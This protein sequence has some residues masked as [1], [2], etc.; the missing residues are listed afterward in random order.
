MNNITIHPPFRDLIPPLTEEEKRELEAAIVTD[1]CR[2][3]LTVWKEHGILLDGHH[4]FEICGRHD[5]PYQVFEVSFPTEADAKSWMIRNQLARRN[6]P[7]AVR[8]ELALKLK[9][10]LTEQEPASKGGR[11]RKGAST[12]LGQN[13]APVSGKRKTRDKLAEA[14]GVSH[15]T[16]TKGAKVLSS[17]NTE[18]IADY[19]AGKVSTNKAAR[20]VAE[21]KPST[22]RKSPKHM[23]LEETKAKIEAAL[24]GWDKAPQELR[25]EL[26]KFFIHYA[27]ELKD[28][29]E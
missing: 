20:L 26:S 19:K 27:W 22:A 12:K 17:G 6:L 2:D 3:P 13:S 24:K 14:A 1:G 4:R 7:E 25:I 5:L 21:D 16:F 23:G 15:D 29:D 10:R 11:P 9:N 8:I 28:S 18:V